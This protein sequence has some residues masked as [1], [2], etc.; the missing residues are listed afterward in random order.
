MI[1]PKT[2]TFLII[3]GCVLAE[4]LNAKK[5]S[6]SNGEGILKAS[7]FVD[8]RPDLCRGWA[9]G[10]FCTNQNYFPTQCTMCSKTC[11]Q[12]CENYREEIPEWQAEYQKEGLWSG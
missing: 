7:D 10:S 4:T 2:V 12:T 6:D 5:S 8:L 3:I 1:T 9:S 11:K